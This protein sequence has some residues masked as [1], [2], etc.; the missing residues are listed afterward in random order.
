MDFEILF[1]TNACLIL[2]K[3]NGQILIPK[4]C[5]KQFVVCEVV[6]T[7]LVELRI[8]KLDLFHFALMEN[9]I[10]T[11]IAAMLIVISRTFL[12]QTLF[13]SALMEN[14][15]AR[16]TVAWRHLKNIPH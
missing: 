2:Q 8:Y 15:I 16:A 6:S 12:E 9:Q 3:T 4:L 10:D 1:V 5:W 11:A 14:H 7:P 13:H